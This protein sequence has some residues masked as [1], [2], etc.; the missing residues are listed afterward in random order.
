MNSLISHEEK[1]LITAIFLRLDKASKG[2]LDHSDLKEGFLE[3]VGD[4]SK[5]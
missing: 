1:T 2:E 5:A 3:L 4:E